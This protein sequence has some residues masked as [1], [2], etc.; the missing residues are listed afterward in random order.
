MDIDITCYADSGRTAHKCRWG[1]VLYQQLSWGVLHYMTTLCYG[2]AGNIWYPHCL[3][4]MYMRGED[5]INFNTSSDGP[6][7]DGTYL[8][9]QMSSK[10]DHK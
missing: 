2:V 8:C 1:S 4:D 9:L 3:P 7:I 10:P 5:S 6:N